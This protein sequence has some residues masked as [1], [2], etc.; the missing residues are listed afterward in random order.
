MAR[1]NNIW[2]NT[3]SNGLASGGI[4][5]FRMQ[6]ANHFMDVIE[7]FITLDCV[8]CKFGNNKWRD[9][10]RKE[11]IC[12]WYFRIGSSQIIR[13]MLH[14]SPRIW[15]I[16]HWQWKLKWHNLFRFQFY[17]EFVTYQQYL[18]RLTRIV[19]N[20]YNIRPCLFVCVV[21]SLLWKS[22][23]MNYGFIMKLSLTQC[24]IIFT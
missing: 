7:C 6:T 3:N 23:D 21:S 2:S 5:Y 13:D 22:R 8:K 12:L 16:C 10:D 17:P 9:V 19:Y 20:M 1:V 4:P 14:L 18:E 24:A 11:Q 15:M